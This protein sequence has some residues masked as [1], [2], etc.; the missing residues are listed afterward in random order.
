MNVDTWKRVRRDVRSRWGMA[1]AGGGFAVLLGL[2]LFR[3]PEFRPVEQ[4]HERKTLQIRPPG[5]RGSALSEETALR[6]L[7]PLF[8]P[9][10]KNAAP[11]GG[12]APEPGRSILDAEASKLGIAGQRWRYDRQFPPPVML[13]GKPLQAI[14]ALDIVPT[15]GA[16]ANVFGFGR[17]AVPLPEFREGGVALEVVRAEDGKIVLAQRLDAAARPMP[18]RPWQPL[19]FLVAVGPSGLSAPL[20]VSLRS[21]WDDVDSFFKEFLVRKYR[22]AERL[23]PGFYRASI[24]P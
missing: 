21:G 2:S 19:E 20:A 7:A 13:D 15:S 6:D 17:K 14:G 18:D 4:I 23:E 3:G 24:A 22:L 1:A 11:R 9:T 5:E 12:P 10:E 16:E 8:L